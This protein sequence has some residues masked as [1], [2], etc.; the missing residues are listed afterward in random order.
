MI[1]R[2]IRAV[3]LTLAAAAAMASYAQAQQTPPTAAA[4]DTSSTALMPEED[5][6]F[7]FNP[8][9]RRDP[10]EPPY[11]RV[12]SERRAAP[13]LGSRE[14]ISRASKLLDD[15]A[16]AAK[17]KNV[18]HFAAI[19]EN[20][21]RLL[22]TKFTSDELRI[23]AMEI[24]RRARQ[25]KEEMGDFE[26]NMAIE[27]LL[28]A[29]AKR[30]LDLQTQIQRGQFDAV[31]EVYQTIV[32]DLTA[33]NITDATLKQRR[34]ELLLRAGSL[35]SQADAAV[36]R[37]L[38][39]RSESILGAMKESLQKEK[40]EE[41]INEFQSLKNRLGVLNLTNEPLKQSR[42]K[43]LGEAAEVARQAEIG[44]VM[45]EIKKAESTLAQMKAALEAAEFGA[46]NAG[47]QKIQ[48]A[49]K[50]L[51][52][53]DPVLSER[54][55]DMLEKAAAL[56]RSAK[57]RTEFLGRDVKV[58]GIAWSPTNPAAIIN[59]RAYAEGDAVDDLTRVEKIGKADV[60]FKYKGESVA[61]GLSQ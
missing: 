23:Y 47:Y 35:V 32:R 60:V 45:R 52:V 18:G 7:I 57:I 46:V 37:D 14:T 3:A 19:Y 10:F 30:L 24:G 53:T 38:L 22:D 43:L 55:A 13:S 2:T 61:R 54:K 6:N 5:Q 11:A 50:Q 31:R 1:S 49:L 41:V 4:P 15:L 25:M 12:G 34:D 56:D 29:A 27:S 48:E 42:D 9:G 36:A 40:F 26:Q 33:P 16:Q 58:N 59:G 8:R 20:L 39:A 44:A 21:T 51:K 28:Q 17:A